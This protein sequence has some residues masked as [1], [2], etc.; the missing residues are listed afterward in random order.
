MGDLRLDLRDAWRALRASLPSTISAVATLA[1]GIGM[2]TSIFSVVNGVVLQPLPFPNEDRLVTLCEHYPGAT[3]DWCGIAPPNVEDIAER[4]RTIEA[5]GIGRQWSYH[6]DTPSGAE[7]IDAGLASPGLFRALGVRAQLGRL[8]D[9][10]DMIGRQ[11]VVV[12]LAHETWQTRF[13]GRADIVGQVVSLD[14]EP[15]TVIGVLEPGFE[16]PRIGKPDI[17]RPLHINPRDEQHREWRGFV[18]FGRLR[19]GV[20]IDAARRELASITSSL[21]TD[22]FARTEDWGITM[23]S[24]RDLVIGSARPMLY[25]FLGAVGLV[26]LIG[27]ANVANLLLA[28]STARAREI[29]LRAALG[30]TPG[31]IVRTLLVESLVLALLG[32]VAGVA[33]AAGATHVFKVVA[34]PRIPRLAQVA[35]DGRV[36]VFALCLSVLTVFVFGLAPAIRSARV[37]LAQTL[38]EG[39]RGSGARRGRLSRVLVVGELALAVVLVAAGGMLT[40]S[41]L[42]LVAWQPGFEQDHLLTFSIFA[43]EAN[44]PSRGALVALLKRVEGDLTTIPGVRAVASASAG[45]LFGGRETYEMEIAGR[46]APRRASV[47]WFDTSPGYFATFGVPIVRGRALSEQDVV[48]GP[49]VGVVNET[50]AARFWPN[51]DPIG[52]T[53][54]YGVGNDRAVFRVVG[55]ARDI[56]PLRPDQPLE[57]Q[58]YWSNRQLPRPVSY[59][60]VRTTVPPATLAP[61]IRV[62]IK[63]IDRDLEAWSIT[64]LSGH[65]NR[66]LRTP[67]F[68]MLLVTS[69]GV[70]ALLFAAIGTYGLLNYLAAQRTREIGIRLALGAMPRQI[71]G[72]IIGGGLAL[73]M[74]GIALGLTATLLTARLI[75]SQLVG[76]SAVDPLTLAASALVLLVVAALACAVP[77]WKASRV[78]PVSTLTAV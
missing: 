14:K 56:P 47:R 23:I 12:L 68:T 2:T 70:A 65:L 74:V 59:F 78:D 39:G 25:M 75:R 60:I 29:G 9:D 72:G 33:L 4:S 73:A 46:G 10:G 41:F 6:L 27:C 1:L 22:H 19:E 38:R 64:L 63:S 44:Y 62:R 3:A 51:E 5:I 48:D 20:A 15:V 13:G 71:F 77:A 53:L 16:V 66:E 45:P 49:L 8:I 21:R 32:G 18:A 54:T 28:R 24:T 61:A 69:F 43:P 76:V 55:V 34:P 7:A 37:D 67:R 17:W 50:L 58:L 26:L 52:K 11:S 42:T 30:A 35:I 31:R 57:S 40:R 36:L